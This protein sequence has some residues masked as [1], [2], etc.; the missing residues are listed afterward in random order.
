MFVL[1]KVPDCTYFCQSVV[2][3]SMSCPPMQYP[4]ST[5]TLRVPSNDYSH[6]EFSMTFLVNEDVSN[7][8]QMEQWFRTM[9]AFTDGFVNIASTRDWMSEQGQLIVISNKK[10]P[11]ARFTF[12]G[13]FPTTLTDF[14]FD[15][16][17]TEAKN[18][19]AT[20]T[21]GFTYMDREDM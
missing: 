20:A 8:K 18:I 3:P 13:L 7:Y 15:N 4:L 17:D 16:T 21:F 14:E 12:R 6:S 11:V 5:S 1:P 10:T 2:F 9:V 19:V